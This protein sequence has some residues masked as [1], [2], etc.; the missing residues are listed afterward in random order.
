MAELVMAALV[1]GVVL[2][3]GVVDTDIVVSGVGMGTVDTGNILAPVVSDTIS[4]AKD[5]MDIGIGDSTLSVCD[6][7]GLDAG[8]NGEGV[9]GVDICSSAGSGIVAS[10][11]YILTKSTLATAKSIAFTYV[12]LSPSVNAETIR[13]S[14]TACC[15]ILDNC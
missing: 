10:S 3:S 6:D 13:S 2:R 11:K 5:V 7:F 14:D 8:P 4:G 12:S 15:S 9:A 1:L